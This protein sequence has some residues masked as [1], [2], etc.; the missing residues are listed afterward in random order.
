MDALIASTALVALALIVPIT[1]LAGRIQRPWV[2]FAGAAA[3]LLV[4]WFAPQLRELTDQLVND[5][6]SARADSSRVRAALGRIAV[7]RWQRDGVPDNPRTW[8]VSTADSSARMRA[9]LLRCR[10]CWRCSSTCSS[11]VLASRS[12]CA[13]TSWAAAWRA[14]ADTAPPA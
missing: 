2:W 3:V 11:V 10:L 7:E 8:L 14:W 12:A 9:P 5:F 1:M 4:S 6:S 13:F